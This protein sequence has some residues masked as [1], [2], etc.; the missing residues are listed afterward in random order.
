[1]L[2]GRLMGENLF[3][4]YKKLNKFGTSQKHYIILT[5]QAIKHSNH[6]HSSQQACCQRR[7]LWPSSPLPLCLQP[8]EGSLAA[9]RLTCKGRRL[10]I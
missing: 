4:F 8:L 7:A 6:A 5:K 3:D 2:H 10:L 1:M 9:V